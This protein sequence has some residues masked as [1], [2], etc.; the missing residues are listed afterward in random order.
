MKLGGKIITVAVIAVVCSLVI[1]LINQLVVLRKQGSE[2]ILD[3]MR[4]MVVAGE[5][6]R[7][8]VADMHQQKSFKMEEL[9]EEAKKGD[10]RQSRAYQTIPIVAAWQSI[11]KAA[12]GE[13]YAFRVIKAQARNPKNLPKPDEE[14]ILKA[15]ED[16]TK[17]E[18]RFVDSD[19]KQIIYARPIRLTAD[20]LS[21][22]GDPKTSPTGDGK[23]FLGFQMEGWKVGEVHGA[24]V[25]KSSFSHL[26]ALIAR[27]FKSAL[28]VVVPSMSLFALVLGVCLHYGTQRG[29][30]KPLHAVV[31][32]IK[33][34]SEK[35][36]SIAGEISSASMRLAEAATE[37]AASLE[38]T[39]SALVEI[40]SM[41]Q[42][43]AE[44]ADQSQALAAA[45]RKA[46]D[47]G[48]KDMTEMVQAMREIQ[49]ASDNIAAIIKKIDEIA[50]QTNI[51]ALNAAVEAAR[52]GD[53]GMGFAV[54]AEEVRALAQRSA[55]AAKETA[56][57]IEDSIAK[58]KHGAIV[59][60]KVSKSLSD[61][62]DRAQKLD[63]LVKEIAGGSKEQS[64]GVHQVTEAISQL[65]KITQSN[66]A[67]SEESASSSVELKA[68]AEHLDQ[69]INDL[70]K[71]VGS[72][73]SAL[74]N[75]TD[76]K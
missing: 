54:V 19:N 12:A 60:T 61:I 13:G 9:L 36:V 46:A 10:L 1:S 64:E 49:T 58:S 29:I 73:S 25:L 76:I 52:A 74:N 24:F 4:G 20:C 39:S 7:S 40:S 35:E 51:L 15:M 22:H 8:Q 41:T 55:S 50:F 57:K 11:G 17:N 42:R 2:M 72:G 3:S 30:I 18:I 28:W 70:I 53:A 45:T 48:A 21:C 23:D 27:G 38:E 32:A 68:S 34:D 62:L 16:G 71:I 47:T 43:N 33:A 6:I 5:A 65:D 59:S 26:N 63:A 67:T 14:W 66:A 44:N 37:Q 56:E 75:H 31:N 69:S